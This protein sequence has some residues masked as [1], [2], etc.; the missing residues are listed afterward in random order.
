MTTLLEISRLP[1]RQFRTMLRLLSAG[2]YVSQA[3]EILARRSAAGLEV[4]ADDV[5]TLLSSCAFNKTQRSISTFLTT[6][7]KNG[8]LV[9][10]DEREIESTCEML[11]D[12]VESGSFPDLEDARKKRSPEMHP[13]NAK[14]NASQN[15]LLSG[16]D[17]QA[18]ININ[19]DNSNRNNADDAE[20]T[21]ST[22]HVDTVSMESRKRKR[23]DEDN[24]NREEQN[25]FHH[26]DGLKSGSAFSSDS[27][28]LK[29]VD[30][31]EEEE[32]EKNAGSTLKLEK[33]DKLKGGNMH[34]QGNNEEDLSAETSEAAS[35][36]FKRFFDLLSSKLLP[37]ES[38]W[39]QKRFNKANEIFLT[40]TMP[41]L[42]VTT[43]SELK[44]E[45]SVSSTVD[46][47]KGPMRK[48]RFSGLG[49]PPNA[50]SYV[51]LLFAALEAGDAKA[52]K[53]LF[54]ALTSSGLIQP[55]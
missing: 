12:C 36:A 41:P 21:S 45:E 3:H 32:E 43:G 52:G 51:I 47:S 29:Q 40:M 26:N 7:K 14:N 28:S 30:S 5:N 48:L 33:E 18:T 53:S 16:K 24:K 34:V 8:K 38:E 46:E 6:L 20:V 50:R 39:C 23:T 19:T 25:Q 44:E 13:Q 55:E 42:E 54:N 17:T 9:G 10:R 11:L 49:I 1:G 35:A 2:M 4:Q 37:R 31:Q 15:A 22:V 27:L